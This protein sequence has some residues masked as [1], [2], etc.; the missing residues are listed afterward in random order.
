MP[1]LRCTEVSQQID[2][3]GQ[4]GRFRH[5][6]AWSAFPLIA[7]RITDIAGPGPRRHLKGAEP[8]SP[9]PASS[10]FDLLCDGEGVVDLDAEIPD[11]ALYL[12]SR[13]T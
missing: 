9:A 11:G 7:S 3:M 2:V 8:L 5:V 13:G 1:V 10:D 12:M 4:Y 6:R